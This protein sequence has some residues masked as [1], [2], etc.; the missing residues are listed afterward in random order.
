ML[1]ND[2][3]RIA[4]LRVKDR[5]VRTDMVRHAILTDMDEPSEGGTDAVALGYGYDPSV[6]IILLNDYHF[7]SIIVLKLNAQL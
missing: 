4:L 5:L 1:V 7:F 2:T 3:N 6:S